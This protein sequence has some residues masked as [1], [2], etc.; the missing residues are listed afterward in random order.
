[1]TTISASV[2]H[3][4]AAAPAAT[5]SLVS[6]ALACVPAPSLPRDE[7]GF[8]YL[9]VTDAERGAAVHDIATAITNGLP[10]L[11]DI[12]RRELAA[13]LLAWLPERSEAHRLVLECH[14]S[15]G[16]P[17][18]DTSRTNSELR[19]ALILEEAREAADELTL[20]TGT[21]VGLAKELADLIYVA[22]GTA[23]TEGID[24]DG[25]V[26]AVHASNMSKLVDGK[27]IMRDDGKFLKGPDYQ[28]PDMTP[29][30][31]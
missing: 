22:H 5:Q 26:R 25:A 23:I 7:D 4:V 28:V 11:S 19:A 12:D 18:D 14:Q 16:L 15:F 30:V 17:V 2:A 27:P 29:F 10:Y 31:P 21:K 24:L 8:E 1:V 6:C 13:A 20:P 9:S 3:R